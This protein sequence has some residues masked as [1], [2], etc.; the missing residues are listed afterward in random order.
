ME[1]GVIMTTPSVIYAVTCCDTSP[2][3]HKFGGCVWG[4]GVEYEDKYRELTI[5]D[6]NGSRY[7]SREYV[8]MLVQLPLSFSQEKVDHYDELEED[9]RRMPDVILAHYEPNFSSIGDFEFIGG[10]WGT[11]EKYHRRYWP[12]VIG[13]CDFY[14]SAK[15]VL[16]LLYADKDKALKLIDQRIQNELTRGWQCNS[17]N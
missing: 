15:A 11:G 1:L 13:Q 12:P 14:F 5:F 17:L 3:D 16:K 7:Y 4:S 2:E 9:V 8:E 6:H 10:M